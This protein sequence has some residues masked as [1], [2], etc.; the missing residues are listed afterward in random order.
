MYTFKDSKR[1]SSKK[2]RLLEKLKAK[3]RTKRRKL[4]DIHKV[5]AKVLPVVSIVIT[6]HAC[7]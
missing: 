1:A 4:P 5:L 2:Q 3:K 7:S 6:M